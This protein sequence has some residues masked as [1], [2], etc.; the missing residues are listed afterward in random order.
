MDARIAIQNLLTNLEDLA[1]LYR[2]LLDVV[3]KERDLLVSADLAALD[4]NN[5]EKEQLIGKT[6][7]ADLLRLKLAAEAA[8]AVGADSASP[9]LLEIA[10]KTTGPE[11][12]RLRSLHGAL[13]TLITR[14][15]ELNRDNETYARKALDTLNGAMNDIK[16]SLSGKKTYGGKGHYKQGP[17][18]SGNFVSKEA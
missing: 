9:R 16:D 1:K 12:D 3:R 11:A 13:E 17:Q 7:L 14:V 15:S 18:V 5:Q 4:L 8:A 6:K 10:A 2:R